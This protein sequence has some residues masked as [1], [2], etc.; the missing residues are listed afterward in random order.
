M[1]VK[2]NDFHAENITVENSA[3]PVGQAVALAVEA[4][5]CSFLNCK[6][7]GN[8]DT[9]YVAG[10][11]DRQY[12]NECY[13]EGTTD[14]IFGEATALFEKCAI[15]IKAD[16]YITAASTPQDVAF[17]FVFKKCVLTASPEVTNAFLGRPWRKYAKVVFLNCSMGNFISPEGWS[18]WKGTDNDK[19]AFYAEYK[20][21]GEGAKIKD[22]ISWSHQLN[23]EEA[24][25]YNFKN[26]FAGR[27]NWDPSIAD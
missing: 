11:N 1:F 25:K 10:E 5:R 4:D 27:I 12:F 16:S 7:I 24:D 15:K 6:L 3:G 22:R 9:L 19:T 23:K 26:I 8:Q 14:F 18:K 2:G 20:S 13:I 21:T 17:G